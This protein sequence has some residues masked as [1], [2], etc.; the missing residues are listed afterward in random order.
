MMIRSL[1]VSKKRIRVLDP[2]LFV[3]NLTLAQLDSVYEGKQCEV[4]TIVSH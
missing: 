1:L 3:L 4:T 2:V